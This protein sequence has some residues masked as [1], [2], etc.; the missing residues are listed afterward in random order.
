MRA[1]A[2][3]GKAEDEAREWQAKEVRLLGAI[4]FWSGVHYLGL[5]EQLD[6]R[7]R[8]FRCLS[9]PISKVTFCS[10]W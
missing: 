7:R 8:Y 9:Y 2:G 6:C 4:F 10:L 5:A 1:V 3:A